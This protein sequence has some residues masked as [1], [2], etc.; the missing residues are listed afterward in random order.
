M[1]EWTSEHVTAWVMSMEN[2]EQYAPFFARNRV[3]GLLLLHMEEQDFTEIGVVNKLHQRR[4]FVSR[5]K[6]N[7]R[8]DAKEAGEEISDGED[9]A[10]L[11]SETPSEIL[12]D[13]SDEEEDESEEESDGNSEDELIP[14]EEELLELQQDEDNMHILVKYKGDGQNYP[15]V[16]D[17]VRCHYS[18]YISDGKSPPGK[19]MVESSRKIRKRAMEFVLGIG[20]VI[21]GWDRAL[22]K[23]SKLERS[24]VTLQPLYAYG[25]EGLE[26]IIPPKSVVEIDIELISFRQRPC[27]CYNKFSA[28]IPASYLATNMCKLFRLYEK[29]TSRN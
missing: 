28:C 25:D 14:T 23:M 24:I 16:G 12:G 3:D 21:P 27:A 10:S 5:K 19:I 15:K 7:D 8:Y 9:E 1:D 26:P 29:T 2:M 13:G 20:Q 6:F 4:I 18:M 22:M 17:I 11:G